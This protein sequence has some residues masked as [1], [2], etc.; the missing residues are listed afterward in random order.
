LIEMPHRVVPQAN[1]RVAKV[2]RRRMTPAEFRLWTT[3]R[4]RRFNGLKFRRQVPIGPYIADFFCPELRL[5]VEVD[6]GQHSL[7]QE[8]LADQART[9][10]FED[11]GYRVL[12]FSNRDV[13]RDAAAIC[14][15]IAAR[16]SIDQPSP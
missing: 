14:D 11:R 4:D 1:R 15:V 8:V 2:M 7:R 6:G 13:L 16:I 9:A 12:R 3:L 5:I 10:W